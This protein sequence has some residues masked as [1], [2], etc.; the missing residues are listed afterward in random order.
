M[1]ESGNVYKDYLAYAQSHD[2][3][4]F[5]LMRMVQHEQWAKELPCPVFRADGT[6]PIF[7]N[8]GRIVE[9]YLQILSAVNEYGMVS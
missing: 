1:Y 2:Q 5:P 8:A 6:K 9:Q 3:V 7:E 4:I